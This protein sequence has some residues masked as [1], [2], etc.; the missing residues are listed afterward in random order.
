MKN[1]VSLLGV[2]AA[3]A[4]VAA[5]ATSGTTPSAA[6]SSR[7]NPDSISLAEIEATPNVRN[8][9]EIVQRLRPTWLTKARN[10]GISLSGTQVYTPTSTGTAGMAGNSTSGGRILVYLDNTQLGDASTL[11]DVQTNSI[12]SIRF[13][14]ASTATALLPGVPPEVIAGAIV[15]HSHSR[16][17]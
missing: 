2:A 6:T 3:L 8:A 14:D 15:I 16:S 7:V 10:S 5:C 9:Y 17:R 4:V 13:M 1:H 11:S 12:G